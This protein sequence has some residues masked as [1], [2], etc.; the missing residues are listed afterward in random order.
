[1]AWKIF[2]KVADAFSDTVQTTSSILFQTG[3]K[4]LGHGNDAAPQTETSGINFSSSPLLSQTSPLMA[5]GTQAA[6]TV[7]EETPATVTVE[8]EV[9]A[10]A[11]ALAAEEEQVPEAPSDF[12]LL[13][14]TGVSAGYIPS[15]PVLNGGSTDDNAPL[16]KG[17]V[18]PGNTVNIYNNGVLIASTTADQNG[19]WSTYPETALSLGSNSITVTQVNEFGNESAHSA[20]V[21]IEITHLPDAQSV[22]ITEV[23][24]VD[25]NGNT[26]E[27]PRES[28]TSATTTTII[29]SGTTAPNGSV[30]VAANEITNPVGVTR[31][32]ANGNWTVEI[33]IDPADLTNGY[34]ELIALLPV[35]ALYFTS[36]PVKVNIPEEPTASAFIDSIYDNEGPETGEVAS[37]ATIDDLSPQL[38][39]HL[40]QPLKDGDYILITRTD[41]NGNTVEA[42]IAHVVGNDWTFS[43]DIQVEGTY[44]YQA[45]VMNGADQPGN[46]SDPFELTFLTVALVEDNVTLTIDDISK[47]SGSENFVTADGSAGRG[48]YGSL[49][50]E[51]DFV[52]DSAHH[53]VL[54]SFDGGLTFVEATVNGNSWY[55]IDTSAHDSNW[56][57]LVKAV[58]VNNGETL[59]ETGLTSQQVTFL[60]DVPD[61]VTITS[62]PAFADGYTKAEA[63]NGV[64]VNVALAADTRAGDTLHI[65]WGDSTYDY[66]LTSSDIQ[67]GKVTVHV[68]SY[69]TSTETTTSFEVSAQ[70][71]GQENTIGLLDSTNAVGIEVIRSGYREDFERTTMSGE[72]YINST[73][74]FIAYAFNTT[75]KLDGKE[76]YTPDGG[77][78]LRLD[79]VKEGGAVF[80]L[81]ES[82]TNVSFDLGK[83]PVKEHQAVKIEVY[84][85]KGLLIHVEYVTGDVKKDFG[86]FDYTAEAGR[87]IGMVRI[88]NSKY[89]IRI[90]NFETK[91]TAE[92][93]QYRTF[94]ENFN[95][96]TDR[97]VNNTFVGNNI[98]VTGLGMKID[99]CAGQSGKGLRVNKKES[100]VTID[101]KTA[102][103]SVSFRIG[104]IH[105]KDTAVIKV[106]G[107]DGSLLHQTPVNEVLHGKEEVFEFSTYNGVK[108]DKVEIQLTGDSQIFID[109]FSSTLFREYNGGNGTGTNGDENALI[110]NT[111]ET[112]YGTQ[113]DDLITMS[114]N[115]DSYFAD[116]GQIHAGDGIDTLKLV[117]KENLVMD[118]AGMTGY[119]NESKISG[120]EVF[121]ISGVSADGHDASN[122]LKISLND[123][124]NLG[125]TNAFHQGAEDTVQVMV[126]G[127]ANDIVELSGLNGAQDGGWKQSS[128]LEIDGVAY[129][130]YQRTDNVAELLIQQGVVTSF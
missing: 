14:Q 16:M 130:V 109:N 35:G 53:K 51:P 43:D 90:D 118:L 120:V 38:R 34:L 69:V 97:V 127:T 5:A 29:L 77:K 20:P 19:D 13:D 9:E 57:I 31:A 99:Y 10:N 71:I 102:A 63:A 27:L 116:K 26:V 104:D 58:S 100:L 52:W 8:V 79:D 111:W 96:D 98:T 3:A 46:P 110:D 125:Q 76:K 48:V 32:D 37:G 4:I 84:D 113:N 56:N 66:T 30:T 17:S 85:V 101:L 72:D 62:I 74:N 91:V 24:A 117:G 105:K 55:A 11:V 21:D 95:D 39:G 78:A 115:S 23:L 15:T 87:Y 40:D 73:N 75:L 64:D 67:A 122:T 114:L 107:T 106:Y 18:E 49:S 93:S 94:V 70:I 129:D 89:N 59:S 123:V 33:Q 44:S 54:V 92:S 108:I 103:E 61:A 41:A 47:D 119:N 126:K 121:D 12:T 112:Y 124:L 80:L 7:A 42:G 83:L 22:Y 1:M 86:H 6:A 28:Y 50:T 82:A 25:E 128:T 68:P 2:G 36:S 65:V 45:T 81:K 88:E 60:S